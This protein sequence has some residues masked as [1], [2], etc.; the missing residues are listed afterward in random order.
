MTKRTAA[1]KQDLRA[2]DDWEDLWQGFELELKSVKSSP[3]TLS[4][5]RDGGD[6]FHRWCAERQLTTDPRRIDKQQIQRFLVWLREEYVNPKNGNRGAAEATVRARFSCLRRF[7]NWC[8]ED[9]MIEHSPM[10]GMHGPRVEVIAPDVM[11]DEEVEALLMACRGNDFDE[12]R[13]MALLHLMLETGLRRSEAASIMVEDVDFERMQITIFRGKGGKPRI[14]FLNDDSARDLHRYMR[15]RDLHH[16]PDKT[17]ERDGQQVHPLW[18]AQ[19]GALSSDGV[20]HIWK[21]RARM[22]GIERRTFP[23]LAR[24]TFGHRAKAAGLTDEDTMTLGGWSDHK[25]M[26]RYGASARQE[27]AREAYKRMARHER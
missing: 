13:D 6:L 15:I 8:V 17:I 7:F 3:R 25:S 5:Y 24:H 12:R 19:K 20:H 10:A 18:L 27:R 22:A 11:T 14:A 4:I 26:L 23:H 9:G 16:A 21:R 2:V 1:A